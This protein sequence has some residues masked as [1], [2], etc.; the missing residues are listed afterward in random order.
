M[1][2][3]SRIKLASLHAKVVGVETAVQL[4]KDKM[5]VGASGFTKAGNSKVVLQAL[6]VREHQEPLKITLI[7]G[8]SK[9][10]GVSRLTCV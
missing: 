6:A 1:I 4:F 7:S 3:L 2:D 5:V 8:A 10:N 9:E